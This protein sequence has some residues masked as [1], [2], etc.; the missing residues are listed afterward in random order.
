MLLGGEEAPEEAQQQSFQAQEELIQE[1]TKGPR[2]CGF[3]RGKG[4]WWLEGRLVVGRIWEREGRLVVGRDRW[5]VGFGRG[6]EV[7]GWKG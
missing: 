7:G 4:G 2:R 5:L 1:Q 3:G 6:R